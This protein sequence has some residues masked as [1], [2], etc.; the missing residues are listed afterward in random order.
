LNRGMRQGARKREKHDVA[1]YV[2][3]IGPLLTDADVTPTGG[4]ETQVL[5]L[6][7]ALARSGSKVRLVVFDVPGAELPASVDGVDIYVRPPYRTHQSL[8]KLREVAS[9]WKA[10]AAADADVV[11]TRTAGEHVGLVGLSAKATRRRFVFASASPSDFDLARRTAKRLNRAL[12]RLGVHTADEIVVQTEEQVALCAE[13]FGRSSVLIRSIAEAVPRRRCEPEAFLWIGRLVNYKQPMAFV[14]L[15]RALPRAKFWMVGVPVP[16]SA[17]G[18]E[19]LSLVE[20]QAA[21]L[22]NLE[23]LPPRP[24][25]ALMGL[26]ERAVAVVSTSEFEGMPNIFLEGWARGVPALALECDPDNVIERYELGA[27]AHASPE[28]FV[29]QARRLWDG[30]LDQEDIAERCRRYIREQHSAEAVSAAWQA[31]LSRPK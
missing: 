2:P 1:F 30:R 12:F 23:V 25:A 10:V 20:R 8:G 16:L 15:A 26:V 5:L 6:A 28:R 19:L 22:P 27:F 29:E 9:L 14:E 21:E 17:E 24:R 18:S 11:V 7:R 4:A 13:R 31:V 3:W